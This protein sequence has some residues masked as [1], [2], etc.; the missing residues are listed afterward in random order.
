MYIHIC[1]YIHIHFCVYVLYL[2]G[3]CVYI[4]MYIYIYIHTYIHTHNSGPQTPFHDP[5]HLLHHAPHTHN[6]R[7][8]PLRALTQRQPRSTAPNTRTGRACCSN[9]LEVDQDGPVA[10]QECGQED[11]KTRIY[12]SIFTTV[13]LTV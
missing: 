7:R 4:Y 10:I 1:V 11:V 2:E 3:V 8:D 12:L 9:G 5:T 13:T 6:Q